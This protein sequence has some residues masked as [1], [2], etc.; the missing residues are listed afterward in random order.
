M[1]SHVP[2]RTM[3]DQLD[4]PQH[5]SEISK[6]LSIYYNQSDFNGTICG[7]NHLMMN[8]IEQRESKNTH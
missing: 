5:N 4:R 8:L 1:F 7:A 6:N 3:L 2:E